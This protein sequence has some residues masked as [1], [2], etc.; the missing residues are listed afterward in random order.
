[1]TLTTREQSREGRVVDGVAGVAHPPSASPLPADAPL[2][3]VARAPRPR[4]AGRRRVMLGLTEIAGYYTGLRDALEELGVQ[5]T[6]V[7]LFDHPFQYGGSAENGLIRVKRRAIKRLLAGTD[8]GPRRLALRVAN[9]VLDAALLVWALPR[10]DVFVFGY[11]TTFLGRPHVELPLM[12]LLGK[13]VIFVFHGSE[14]RPTYLDGSMMAADRG[15]DLAQCVEFTRVYKARVAAIDR[16]A[17]VVVENPLSGHFHERPFV[18]WFAVGIPGR[19]APVEVEASAESDESGAERP[20]RI[21]HSPSHPEAKGTPRIRAA[22]ERL[23]ARGH[24]VELVEIT[25]RPN[26]EVMRELA[27]CD[28]VVDQLYSDTPMAGFAAEA[29]RF[30]KPAVVGGYGAPAMADAIPPSQ[31]PPTAYC[32][33][34]DLEATLERLVADA[35]YRV[36]LGRRA[37]EFVLRR[38]APRRVARRFL[39]LIDGDVP[40]GWLFDP[41]RVSHVHGCALPEERAREL[42]R[43]VVEL[44]GVGALC[45]SDKPEMERRVLRMA[46]LA[47]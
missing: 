6:L 44:G 29:A 45:L 9:K 15:M 4:P 3:R 11:A 10:F 27:R 1:M 35:A 17:D 25:G 21:L 20:V 40:P 37:R 34:D 23:R 12:R 2:A 13:R 38:W 26:A 43:G 22:V 30:G 19:A 28:L 33:P 5:A 24:R 7:S 16:Y 36:D 14:S 46:G 42:V 31:M 18:S 32:H 39:R 47:G 41:A 8:R